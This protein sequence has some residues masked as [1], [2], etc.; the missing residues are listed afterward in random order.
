[1][2]DG[3][4]MSKRDAAASLL[5]YRD[6]GVDPDAMLNFLLRMGWGPRQD[7][8]SMAVIDRARAVDLFLDGGRMK[9][10]PATLDPAKL[11]AYDRKYRARKLSI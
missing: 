2:M 1:M 5:G 7:D 6:A 11:A 8:K 4:K 9:A 10:S 3:K